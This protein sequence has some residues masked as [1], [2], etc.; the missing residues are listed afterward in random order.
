MV[1]RVPGDSGGQ[2]LQVR[3]PERTELCRRTQM[4]E[5]PWEKRLQ[6]RR[7]TGFMPDA[8]M[9]SRTGPF[10]PA[11]LPSPQFMGLWGGDN[12]Y[13]PPAP[14]QPHK[15]SSSATDVILISTPERIILQPRASSR[16]LKRNMKCPISNAVRW[17]MSGIQ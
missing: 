1:L 2:S 8:H 15:R 10:P 3:L 6:A 11:R 14:T 12:N 4:D 7:D 17:T 5:G 9:R 16:I 13:A